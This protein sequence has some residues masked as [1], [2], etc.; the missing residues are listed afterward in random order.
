MIKR[1][2]IEDYEIE[3]T[4]DEK[5][6]EKKSLKYRGPHYD[7]SFTGLSFQGYKQTSFLLFAGLVI[8]HV[9]SGFAANQ[10]MYQLYVA[11]PYAIAFLPLFFLGL[12]LL[13]LPK[14]H[15]KIQRD[16]MEQSFKRIA[17][18]SGFT[19][20]LLVVAI[21]GEVIYL[22]INH[23][24]AQFSSELIYLIPEIISVILIFALYRIQKK[25]HIQMSKE[26]VL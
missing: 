21:L 23:S 12:G 5:G 3:V 2:Y 16:E 18:T 8:T 25:T 15:L 24:Y 22:I 7:V 6:R 17:I 13:E 26:K 11:L 10:G 19:L 20:V 9:F 14:K 1:R 4:L